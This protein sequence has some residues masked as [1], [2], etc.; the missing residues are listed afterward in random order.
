MINHSLSMK[1]QT[2]LKN[3]VKSS[4]VVIKVLVVLGTNSNSILLI[5]Y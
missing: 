5:Y 3:L 4:S 2:T 1:I